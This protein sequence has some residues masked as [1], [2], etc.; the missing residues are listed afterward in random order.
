MAK[1]QIKPIAVTNKNQ[2]NI[3]NT[4]VILTIAP[5]YPMT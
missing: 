1:T 5:N 4:G 2:A 3:G